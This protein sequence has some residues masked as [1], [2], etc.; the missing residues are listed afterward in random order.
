M[1]LFAQKN[2]SVI[3]KWAKWPEIMHIE[4]S[5]FFDKASKTIE[6]EVDEL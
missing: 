1:F 6:D 5:L 3:H 4:D 2:F